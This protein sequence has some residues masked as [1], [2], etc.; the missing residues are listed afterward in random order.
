MYIYLFICI[1]IYIY[2]YI[3]IYI[4]KHIYIYIYIYIHIHTGNI[5]SYEAVI[6]KIYGES[7][8]AGL[9]GR[10]LYTRILTNGIQIYVVCGYIYI[11]MYICMCICISIYIHICMYTCIYGESGLA[12]LFGRGLYTR[13]LTIGIQIYV[14]CGY[15]Y[16]HMYI[17]MCICISIYICI[18]MY[19][20]IYGESGLA[21]LFGRGLYTRILTNG[22]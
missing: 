21:G 10:G 6:R 4:Y 8:L 1:Y 3:S 17:C 2:I 15:I 7:G 11:H 13:I 20:C 18:C 12:G 22:I 9:F 19:T 16:I 14:V 5:L